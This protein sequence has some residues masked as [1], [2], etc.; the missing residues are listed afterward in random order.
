MLPDT[1][2]SWSAKDT[3][4]FEAESSPERCWALW[5]KREEYKECIGGDRKWKSLPH[6]ETSIRYLNLSDWGKVRSENDELKRFGLQFSHRFSWD[7]MSCSECSCHIQEFS[8]E[9]PLRQ[10]G[11][12]TLGHF[13]KKLSEIHRKPSRIARVLSP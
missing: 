11:P 12:Q 2:V 4:S 9:S 3:H 13:S 5:E 7:L 8:A 1:C 6:Y 10:H